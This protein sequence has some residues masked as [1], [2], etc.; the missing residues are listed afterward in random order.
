MELDHPVNF[1]YGI[2]VPNRDRSYSGDEKS[3]GISSLKKGEKKEFIIGDMPLVYTGDSFLIVAE[4]M[5]KKVIE[6]P[7]TVYTFYTTNWTFAR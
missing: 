4:F 3:L 7:E 1:S 2:E 5:D 6:P